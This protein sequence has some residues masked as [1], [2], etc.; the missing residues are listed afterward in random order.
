MAEFIGFSVVVAIIILLLFP[1]LV[2][3]SEAFAARQNGFVEVWKSTSIVQR[4]KIAWICFVTRCAVLIVIGSEKNLGI[5]SAIRTDKELI[6]A[7]VVIIV[8]VV[9][10]F[11]VTVCFCKA[12]MNN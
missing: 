1:F 10:V 12:R 5:V 4:Q 7:I 8:V 9:V 11:V 3:T 6:R 2:Y